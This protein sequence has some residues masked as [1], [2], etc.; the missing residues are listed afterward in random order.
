MI[1][2]AKNSNQTTDQKRKKTRRKTRTK[3]NKTKNGKTTPHRPPKKK[4]KGRGWGGGGG[5]QS[6]TQEYVIL[7][8]QLYA[9]L[10]IIIH[11]LL[12]VKYGP[13]VYNMENKFWAI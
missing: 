13:S 2:L 5:G 10:Q 6:H 9:S 7:E 3:Q 4:R 8:D 11:S 12:T 1:V